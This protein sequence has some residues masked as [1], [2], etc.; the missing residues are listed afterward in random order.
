M[1]KTSQTTRF[2]T[3]HINMIE[4]IVAFVFAQANIL[5]TKSI[6]AWFDLMSVTQSNLES[7]LNLMGI[8]QRNIT[9]SAAQKKNA[10]DALI[11]ISAAIMRS[12]YSFGV[13]TSNENLIK[14]MFVSRS[15][16]QAKKYT[17]LV[18]YMQ[19]II[20]I[21]TP[22]IPDLSAYNINDALIN[23]W[24][25]ANDLL[26]SLLASAKN[27]KSNRVATNK[28]LQELLR[29]T[30]VLLTDQ[31]D[32]MALNFANNPDTLNYYNTY[33]ANR[34]LNPNRVPTQLRATTVN[35][36]GMPIESTIAI[37]NTTISATT[38]AKGYALLTDLPFG[39]QN[40]IITVNGVS[41]SFAIR[42]KKGQSHSQTF[43][44]E[45]PFNIPAS[46][47]IKKQNA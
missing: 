39:N 22:L 12:V 26:N 10:K 11:E 6:Q 13:K 17:D 15:D 30:I 45:Q 2:G 36:S 44:V 28:A 20:N 25:A 21:V 40:V 18:A 23:Q 9:G 5:T 14:Q 7:I 35:D 19:D 42:F 4:A 37:E 31:A 34:K 16:L 32:G 43:N 8:A 41:K 27:A 24:Q 3:T 29:S 47:P 1:K 38:D 46:K 33:R